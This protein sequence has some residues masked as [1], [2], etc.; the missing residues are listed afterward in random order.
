MLRPAG[1]QRTEQGIVSVVVALMSCFTLLPIA[2]FAVDIGVQR[3]ARRDMQALADLVALDLGRQL[4]GRSYSQLEPYLQIWADKSAARNVGTGRPT[5]VVAELGSIDASAYDPANPGAVFTPITSDAGGTPSA[6]RVTASTTVSFS[7]HGGSGGATRTA[8]ARADADACFRL[9]S[10]AARVSSSGS[11]LNGLI[12]DSLNLS[13]VGYQGLASSNI[14]L[15]DLAAELGAGTPEELM[16]LDNLSIGTLFSAAAHVLQS[17]GGNA[18]NASLLTSMAGSSFSSVTHSHVT[19]SDLIELSSG[20]DSAFAT[21]IN[22]YDLVA[23]TAFVANGDSLLA[24]PNITAGIPGLAPGMVTASLKVIQAPE[25]ACG[26]VGEA[27]VTTSQ[28]K[29]VVGVNLPATS[30]GLLTTSSTFSATVD[31]AQAIGTLTKIQ[32]GPGATDGGIDVRVDSALS[33]VE[34]SLD[35][36]IKSLGIAVASVATGSG[37]TAAGSTST[38]SIRVPPDSYDTPRSTGPAPSFTSVANITSG[39]VHVS[40][41][42]LGLLG[43]VVTGVNSGII[44]AYVNPLT[45]NLNNLLLTPLSQALGVRLAGADVFAVNHPNCGDVSLAG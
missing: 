5:V 16:A 1:R 35:V 2:A 28:V 13:V 23:T 26:H 12:N 30:I 41:L 7:I 43:S 31:L 15:G 29:L 39:D 45:V 6:V 11:L 38:V 33:K 4:D 36:T 10:F 40:G 25:R 21:S 22:L 8:I 19:F 24:I 18:A 17:T 20:S 9:G 44:Q 32:C 3:V 42:S 27:S 14:T 37:G 34:T